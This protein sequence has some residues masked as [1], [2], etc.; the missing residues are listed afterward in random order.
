MPSA[1]EDEIVANLAGGRIIIHVA[2]DAIIFAAIDHPLEAKS[3]PPRVA[4][5][6]RGHIGI[7]FGASE[8]QIPC[9]SPSPFASIV[10]RPRLRPADPSYQLRPVVAETDLEQIGVGFLE[11]FAPSSPNSTTKSISS[12]TSLSS[13]LF[14][15]VT[16]HRITAR[17]SG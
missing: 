3:V 16:R 13:K 14:S 1:Q 17:K 15:S 7:F 6:D 2:R 12:P 4:D 10:N 5:I 9:R 8:W 11:S